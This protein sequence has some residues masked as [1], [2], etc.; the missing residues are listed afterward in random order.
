[1]VLPVNGWNP[2]GY[3]GFSHTCYK[4]SNKVTWTTG[5]WTGLYWL[6]YQYS[7]ET[8]GDYFFFEALVRLLKPEIEFCW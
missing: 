3:S 6:A 1:M 4:P 8:Y 7:C 2:L 5:M